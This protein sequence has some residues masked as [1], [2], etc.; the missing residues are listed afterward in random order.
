MSIRRMIFWVIIPF[1]ASTIAGFL[2]SLTGNTSDVMFYYII[3][4]LACI[5]ENKIEHG[6]QTLGIALWVLDIFLGMAFARNLV[7]FVNGGIKFLSFIGL[8][9]MLVFTIIY[10]YGF[11]LDCVKRN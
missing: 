5:I 2:I 6:H 7:N 9:L 1:A 8:I 11:L 10:M 4:M 3:I